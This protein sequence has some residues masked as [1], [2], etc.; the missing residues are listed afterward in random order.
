[1]EEKG[2]EGNCLE[3]INSKNRLKELRD[4]KEKIRLFL[5]LEQLMV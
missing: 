5:K 4:E 2:E 3:R 1:M